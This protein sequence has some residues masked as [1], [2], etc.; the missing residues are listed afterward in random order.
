MSDDTAMQDGKYA[1]G[2]FSQTANTTIVQQIV[3]PPGDEAEAQLWA[4]NFANT[5]NNTALHN[6]TDWVGTVTVRQ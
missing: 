1:V 3:S 5:L 4:N 2:A 6:T